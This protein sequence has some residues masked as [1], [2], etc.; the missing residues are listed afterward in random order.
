MA[1]SLGRSV[2]PLTS[3]PAWS[4]L[5]DHAKTLAATH[6]RDLFAADPQ[7]G[8]RLIAEGAGV[9]LDF[10]KNRVTD[11]TLSLLMQ[12][13]EQ[14]GLAEHI[15]AMFSGDKINVTENRAVLHVAL[16]APRGSRIDVD[17]IDVVPAV[18]EVLGRMAEFAD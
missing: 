9:F 6:L 2:A 11:E 18:R 1:Q 13:A 8:E 10:S 17:G 12:L 15:E 14:S 7:R 4:Q 3:R 5:K 16:R